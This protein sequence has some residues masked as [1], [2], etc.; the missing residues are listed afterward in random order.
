MDNNNLSNINI[1][2]FVPGQNPNIKLN[3]NLSTDSEQMNVEQNVSDN[4][5]G[6]DKNK[7]FEKNK[8]DISEP[9]KSEDFIIS[10]NIKSHSPHICH[11]N[12][13]KESQQKPHEHL[14]HCQQIYEQETSHIDKGHKI[15]GNPIHSCPPEKMKLPKDYHYDPNDP[16]AEIF[17][18]NYQINPH[19]FLNPNFSEGNIIDKGSNPYF[20]TEGGMVGGA[21]LVGP[22]S[23]IFAHEHP[24]MQKIPGAK[25][26]YDPIGPFGTFGSDKP[27]DSNN[28]NIPDNCND[29]IG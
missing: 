9:N 16:E 15:A 2:D 29:Y 11:F 18:P 28:T 3:P 7:F 12:K 17:N 5:L 1:S 10:S 20:S 27:Q 6:I 24:H 4:S 8:G 26:R 19:Q 21:E 22:N 14:P 25:I 13:E 23:D